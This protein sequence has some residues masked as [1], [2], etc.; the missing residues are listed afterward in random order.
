M[1]SIR[2]LM[3]DDHAILRD[4]LSMTLRLHAD[5]DIVGQ[6]ENGG[7]GL[8]LA[9]ELQP[10]L[11]LLDLSMPD[12]DGIGLTHQ[13][14]QDVPQIRILILSGIHSKTQVLKAIEAGIDGYIVKDATTTELAQAIRHVAQGHSYFH[15]IITQA[16]I[17]QSPGNTTATNPNAKL[18]KREMDVLQLMLTSATNRTIA[19]ALH[20]SEE[21]VRTH[22]KNILRKLEQPN[23][24][25]AV[26]EG[27]R[28]GL[29]SLE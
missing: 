20:V 2:I 15:P 27:V 14:K 26:L 6:A 18:T 1:T 25:Q 11:I 23:R 13:L 17:S 12:I 3:I 19:E 9:K 16:L 10:D 24:T 21:T 5:F 22:V 28:R 8:M 4:G 7:Q 29:I